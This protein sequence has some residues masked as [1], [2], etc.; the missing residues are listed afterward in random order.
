MLG[1]VKETNHFYNATVGCILFLF[2]F[3]TMHL[4]RRRRESLNKTKI[5]E[6]NQE[7]IQEPSKYNGILRNRREL[8]VEIY[9]V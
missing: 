5:Q 7:P 1:E 4:K 9:N 3:A 6:P 8:I 2:I